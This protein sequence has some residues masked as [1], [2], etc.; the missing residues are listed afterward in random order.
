[1]RIPK[2]SLNLFH[3]FAGFCDSGKYETFLQC[4]VAKPNLTPRRSNTRSSLDSP[5]LA[6]RTSESQF[7][8]QDTGEP[9]LEA[10]SKFKRPSSSNRTS[11]SKFQTGEPARDAWSKSQRASSSNKI[12]SVLKHP[13]ARYCRINSSK[14]T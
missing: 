12:T 11:E 9:G 14:T 10:S 3:E 5:T 13:R 2:Y 4:S 8:Q 1:M 6:N 7:Q